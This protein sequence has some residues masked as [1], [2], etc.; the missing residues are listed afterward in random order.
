MSD[1]PPGLAEIHHRYFFHL[2]CTGEPPERWRHDELDPSDG[3]EPPLFELFWASLPDGVPAMVA[4]HGVL[5]P[6]LVARLR[7]G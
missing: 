6:K 2:R 4:E 3:S 1:A 7:A 5:L